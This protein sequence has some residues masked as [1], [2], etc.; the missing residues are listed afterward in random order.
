MV[1]RDGT[2]GRHLVGAKHRS[3]DVGGIMPPLLTIMIVT[4][5]RR[6]ILEKTLWYIYETSDDSE[7]NIWIWDNASTD[8]TPD[9][10]GTLVGWPGVRVFRSK[11]DLGVVG[12]RKRMLPA[13]TTPYVFTLDDDTWLLNRGWAS[14]CSRVLEVDPSIHQ[15]AIAATR[16]HPSNDFGI[17]HTKLDRPFF[18]VPV[19]LPGPKIPSGERSPH[20]EAMA[21]T[22]GITFVNIAGETVMVPES[23]TQLPLAVSGGAA[24]WRTADILTLLQ[25]HDRHPVVDLREAWSFSLQERGTREATIIGYSAHH[26]SPGPIWHLGRCETYWKE[27]CRMAPAI[28]NRTENEQASW[29]EGTR[30]ASGWGQALDDPDDVLPKETL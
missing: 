16:T 7:R 4:M 30:E 6:E 27:R 13:V 18:R 28:Y 12:P 11:V 14:A 1:R 23:G 10:L 17:S 24:A 26:P 19:I 3:G 9:F 2:S 25:K 15:L 21:S 29:L 8:D 20:E 22:P 5:D